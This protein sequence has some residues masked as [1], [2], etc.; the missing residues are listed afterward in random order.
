M[1]EDGA[2]SQ[3]TIICTG[4]NGGTGSQTC[5][6]DSRVT[7]RNSDNICGIDVSNTNE[8]DTGVWHLTAVVLSNNGENT[9][10][11]FQLRYVLFFIS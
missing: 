1:E 3:D 11:S 5:P 7:F 6:Q 8:K 4:T 2:N 9:Q 10:V